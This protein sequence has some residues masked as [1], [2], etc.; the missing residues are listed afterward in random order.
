MHHYTPK[1]LKNR[2]HRPLLRMP[3][4][5]SPCDAPCL[6]AVLVSR[7]SWSVW[8]G[9]NQRPPASKAG[10]LPTDITHRQESSFVGLAGFTPATSG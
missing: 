5:P 2:W 3:T 10:R 1:S 7:V 9:S 4:S 6:R 8:L